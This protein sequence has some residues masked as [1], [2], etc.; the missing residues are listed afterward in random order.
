[1]IEERRI[2]DHTKRDVLII[3]KQEEKIDEIATTINRIESS[4]QR[5]DMRI[6]GTLE[7]MGTHVEDSI[8]WRR[9]IVGVAIS[10]VLSIVGGSIALF[11]LSYNLGAYTRQIVVNTDRLKIIEEDHKRG[12]K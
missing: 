5:L 7:K 3:C 12:I 9:F 4:I 6:N 1:M 11:N 2:Q 8:Y 10:L